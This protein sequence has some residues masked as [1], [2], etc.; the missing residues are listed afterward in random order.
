MAGAHCRIKE[1]L[2]SGRVEIAGDDHRH[3][4]WP[5][6]SPV[7]GVHRAGRYGLNNLLQAY[8]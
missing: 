5:V 4:L 3:V 1:L 2:D 7:E 6:P 8:G